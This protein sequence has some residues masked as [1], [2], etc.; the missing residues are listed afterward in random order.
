MTRVKSA[1]GEAAGGPSRFGLESVR[2]TSIQWSD[3]V[4]GHVSADRVVLVGRDRERV[5]IHHEQGC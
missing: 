2:S 4:Q 1:S 5:V 3:Q